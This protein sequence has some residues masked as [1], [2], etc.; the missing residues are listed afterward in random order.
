[1]TPPTS[2][3]S[4]EQRIADIERIAA[5]KQLKYRYFRACDAKQPDAFRASF[6]D[7]GADIDYERMGKFD[8][9]DGIAD[10]F[11]KFALARVD[12]HHVVLDMHHSIHPDISLLSDTSAIGRWTLRFRQINL[13]DRT[14]KL[15]A[16]EYDD[17][18]LVENGQWKISKCHAHTLWSITRPLPDGAVVDDAL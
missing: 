15:A 17:A 13:V 7:T 14:E 10:V 12:G 16:I 4:L 1:M 2:T 11:R 6:I 3:R 5:I 9:A 8:D 18:Y